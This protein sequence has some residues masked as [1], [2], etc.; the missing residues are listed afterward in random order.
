M[1]DYFSLEQIQFVKNEFEKVI[2]NYDISRF[3]INEFEEVLLLDDSLA[4]FIKIDERRVTAS[5]D[6]C[7]QKYYSLHIE[8]ITYNELGFKYNHTAF[9]KKIC[10]YFH[11]LFIN[12]TLEGAEGT[13]IGYTKFRGLNSIWWSNLPSV[14]IQI[15]EALPELKLMERYEVW[16][17][18]HYYFIVLELQI[19]N[20]TCRC[21]AYT[22]E[23]PHAFIISLG[24][25]FIKTG[26]IS[27]EIRN[28]YNFGK[29]LNDLKGV[30]RK[31]RLEKYM[32][33][34]FFEKSFKEKDDVWRYADKLLERANNGKFDEIA[35][36]TYI[37]P[38]YKWVTEEL[39]LKLTKKLYKQYTVI[40]QYKPFF[41]RSSFGGQMSYDIYIQDLKVAIEYQGKQHFEPVD[42]FGGKEA[43]EKGQIRDNEKRKL[44]KENGIKLVYINFDEVITTDLIKSRVEGDLE[45]ECR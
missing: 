27:N 32:K 34:F 33:Y 8:E 5:C 24:R 21:V 38:I 15:N 26:E 35:R 22:R 45:Y 44:S 2:N 1:V 16:D 10:S 43:F 19:N 18:V 12:H 17:G 14:L 29:M 9:V 20:D 41:L 7:G 30:T 23:K 25:T 28:S 6:L 36:S 3:K 39:V 40:Y 4:L 31:D 37:C 13:Y 11:V 42:Y